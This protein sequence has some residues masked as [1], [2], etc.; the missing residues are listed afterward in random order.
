MR[1]LPI[2]LVHVLVLANLLVLSSE[3]FASAT[4]FAYVVNSDD[5]TVSQFAFDSSTG[6]ARENGYVLTGAKPAGVRVV[7]NKFAYVINTSSNSIYSYSLN[8][9]TGALTRIAGTTATGSSPQGITSTAAFV[10]VANH[11]G[12]SVSAYKVNATTGA[13]T[14]IPGSPFPAGTGPRAISV[15]PTGKFLVVANASAHDILV[16]K[17]NATSGALQHVTGSPFSVGLNPSAIA[18]DPAGHFAFITNAGSNTVSAFKVNATSGF[19]TPVAGSPFGT[20]SNPTAVGADSSGTFLYVANTSGNNVSGYRINVTTGALTTISGSPFATGANPVLVRGDASSKFLFVASGTN[21]ELSAWKI[22][23][24]SGALSLARRVRSRGM[25]TSLA[26]FTTT[27]PTVFAP[28][29]MF[30]GGGQDTGCCGGFRSDTIDS[31]GNPSTSSAI[32]ST[33]RYPGHVAVDLRGRFL[34]AVEYNCCTFP[35][36]GDV[37]SY[38]ITSGGGLTGRTSP[39]GITSGSWGSVQFESS[40]RWV[41][42][43]DRT[44]G[45]IRAFSISSTDALTQLSGSPF[46]ATGIYDLSV[47]PTGRFVFASLNGGGVDVFKINSATGALTLVSGSPFASGS[48]AAAGTATDPTGQFLWVANGGSQN[49]YGFKINP[50][51]GTLSA[52][53]GSP[54]LANVFQVQSMLG[55]PTGRVLVTEPGGALQINTSTGALTARSADSGPDVPGGIA[56]DPSGRFAYLG[57]WDGGAIYGFTIQS[58]GSLVNFG[59]FDACGA[60]RCE[61]M[62]FTG[63]YH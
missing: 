38:R 5:N 27:N 4:R 46:A 8:A 54:F 1:C 61:A 44:A 10:Y 40:G 55:D 49:I 59:L 60:L 18:F 23:S 14:A 45:G 31:S 17:I 63:A 47:D 33:P 48:G 53:S 29:N 16:F 12:N 50:A 32:T 26:L 13:L 11:N 62:T 9:G 3:A 7:L 34:V 21:R 28:V 15:D 43:A 37:I 35:G 20:G 6:Q 30:A 41:Y 22:S 36:P 52:I 56:I 24:V 25:P 2:R 58:D 51:S 39:A 57:E 19:L 42:A